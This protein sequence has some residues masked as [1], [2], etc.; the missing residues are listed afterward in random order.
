MR[1]KIKS[2]HQYSNKHSANIKNI[3][4]KKHNKNVNYYT[5]I[6]Q[7]KKQSNKKQR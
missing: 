7:I 6:N 4:N 3:L 2:T 1:P 5:S